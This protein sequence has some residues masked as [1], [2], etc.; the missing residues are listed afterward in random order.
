[1]EVFKFKS[2]ELSTSFIF[3]KQYEYI[4]HK[5]YSIIKKKELIPVLTAIS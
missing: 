2:T 5:K 3:T 4:F 1:M